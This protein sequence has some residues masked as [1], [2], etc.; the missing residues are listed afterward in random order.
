MNRVYPFAPGS[1]GSNQHP[2]AQGVEVKTL[3]DDYWPPMNG[4]NADFG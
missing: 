2:L 4:M 1:G 3:K